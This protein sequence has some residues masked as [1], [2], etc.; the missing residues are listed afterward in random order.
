M[1]D[2]IRID[3][4]VAVI[5]NLIN[6]VMAFLF[7]ARISGLPQI[8]YVLGIATMIMGFSLGYVAFLNRKNR[9]DKW[10]TV[11]LLPIFIFFIVELLLDYVL[12]LNFRTTVGAA[13]YILLYYVGLWGLIGYSFIFSKKWGFATLATYFINMTMSILPY[14][15]TSLP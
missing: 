10:L 2:Y 9:R 6:I 15:Y 11:L 8:Q 3:L 7:A 12:V 13:P 4:S 1:S 5:A 14:I